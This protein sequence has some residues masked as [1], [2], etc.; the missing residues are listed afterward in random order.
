MHGQFEFLAF[1]ISQHGD[2]DLIS[3]KSFLEKMIENW[4]L[5]HALGEAVQ[6]GD[7]VAFLKTCL[8]GCSVHAVLP[9]VGD[10]QG[11]CVWWQVIFFPCFVAEVLDAEAS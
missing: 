7:D 2:I 3:G 6:L 8:L 5:A 10:E 1:L 11:Q 4:G 9:D